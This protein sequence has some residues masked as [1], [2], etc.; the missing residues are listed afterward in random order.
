MVV[1]EVFRVVI[2]GVVELRARPRRRTLLA[3]KRLAHDNPELAQALPGAIWIAG[4]GHL[5]QALL[6]LLDLILRDSA[7]KPHLLLH[8]CGSVE[9]ANRATQL[10]TT[11]RDVGIEK[12]TVCANRMRLAGFGIAT[13]TR[14]LDYQFTPP[15]DAPDVLLAGF[16]NLAARQALDAT[17][18]KLILDSGIGRTRADYSA[19][20]VNEFRSAEDA[21]RHF[22]ASF[23]RQDDVTSLAES[24]AY[25][26][27]N[28]DPCGRVRL[29]GIAVGV[30]FV[31]LAVAAIGLDLL[32]DRSGLDPVS[33][34]GDL[35]SR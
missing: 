17:H 33:V 35:R 22:R 4:L 23:D 30:P 28:P 16:D 6:F 5:G 8:D 19:F 32:I 2:E 18:A 29:A 14:R 11:S 9:F 3:A 13:L 12:A 20:R 10:L 24:A 31:G 34:V 1:A 15:V 7:T 21:A 27:M 26:R 25:R